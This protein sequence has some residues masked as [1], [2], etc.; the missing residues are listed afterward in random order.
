MAFRLFFAFH[1]QLSSKKSCR[2]LPGQQ[3][4]YQYR[5]IYKWLNRFRNHDVPLILGD[6]SKRISD[7]GTVAARLETIEMGYNIRFSDDGQNPERQF[8][9]YDAL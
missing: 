1:L 5:R 6:S 9:V 2:P 7:Q 8:A 3:R 4:P